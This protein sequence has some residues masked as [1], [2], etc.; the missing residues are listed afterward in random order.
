MFKLRQIKRYNWLDAT[1]LNECIARLERAIPPSPAFEQQ[2]SIVVREAHT[3]I[4]VGGSI[5]IVADNNIYEIKCTSEIKYEHVL[6]VA[7]YGLL[8]AVQNCLDEPR[9]MLLYNVLLD[10]MMQVH[11]PLDN[12]RRI[13]HL[14]VIN[15]LSTF[16]LDD[17]DQFLQEANRRISLVNPSF[18]FASDSSGDH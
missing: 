3:Q 6:Q 2:V 1:V 17:K 8:H 7:L 16:R 14:L 10:E 18:C 4:T 15:K 5:D 11:A 12:I 9:P 13:L